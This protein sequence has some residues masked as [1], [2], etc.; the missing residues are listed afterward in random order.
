M[1]IDDIKNNPYPVTVPKAVAFSVVVGNVG[2]ST[3]SDGL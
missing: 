1:R 3:N 2:A